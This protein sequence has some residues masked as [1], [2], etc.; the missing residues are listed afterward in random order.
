[1]GGRG[2][3]CLTA[4]ASASIFGI[5]LPVVIAPQEPAGVS[6]RFGGFHIILLFVVGALIIRA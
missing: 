3:G 5:G 6:D 4:C 2:H 1:M